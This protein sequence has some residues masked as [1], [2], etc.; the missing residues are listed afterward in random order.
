[1]PARP[2]GKALGSE[3]GKVLRCGLCH[4][5]RGEAEPGL[6]MIKIN[7]DINVQRA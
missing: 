5:Q 7:F 3:K 6:C 1:M 2:S 4:E